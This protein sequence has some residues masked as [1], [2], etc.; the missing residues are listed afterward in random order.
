MMVSRPKVKTNIGEP[1][2][3]ASKRVIPLSEGMESAIKAALERSKTLEQNAGKHWK[4]EKW[5][6][7][8][9]TGGLLSKRNVSRAFDAAHTRAIITSPDLPR[10][11]IHDMRVTFISLA[12]RR[13]VK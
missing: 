1:K 10:I 2:T 7:P 3:E 9:E 11:R 4:A 5:L 8:S 12:L 6:F 13:G